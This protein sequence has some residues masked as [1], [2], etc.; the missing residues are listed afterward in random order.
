MPVLVEGI[1]PRT[2]PFMPMIIYFGRDAGKDVARM[3]SQPWSFR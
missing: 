1:A 2:V 3:A